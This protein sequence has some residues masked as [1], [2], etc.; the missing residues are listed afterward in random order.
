MRASAG[1]KPTVK[2]HFAAPAA[3]LALS[4]A[5]QVSPSTWP[6]GARTSADPQPALPPTNS[7]VATGKGAQTPCFSRDSRLVDSVDGRRLLKG[8]A[9]NTSAECNHKTQGQ[10]PA[11]HPTATP[12]PSATLWPTETGIAGDG[13]QGS[14]L[15]VDVDY[16]RKLAEVERAEMQVTSSPYDLSPSD[17]EPDANMVVMHAGSATCKWNERDG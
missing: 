2:A 16:G 10:R 15:A 13:A 3:A 11:H 7:L 9:A 8:S 5:L 14:A 17:F 12:S 1:A 4:L 6:P